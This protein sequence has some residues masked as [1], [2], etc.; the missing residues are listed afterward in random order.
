MKI[1]ETPV[2][3]LSASTKAVQAI[4]H[5]HARSCLDAHL[6]NLDCTPTRGVPHDRGPVDQGRGIPMRH[7]PVTDDQFAEAWHLRNQGLS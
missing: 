7:S 5:D 1:S 3:R 4:L 6:D 2:Y